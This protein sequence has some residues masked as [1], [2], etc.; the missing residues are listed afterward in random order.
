[1][2]YGDVQGDMLWHNLSSSSFVDQINRQ[3]PLAKI[4]A[5]DNVFF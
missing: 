1:M 3:K 2:G 5:Q 4:G